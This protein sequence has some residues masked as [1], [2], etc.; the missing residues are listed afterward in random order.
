VPAFEP[1]PVISLLIAAAA[2]KQ[3]FCFNAI[4]IFGSIKMEKTGTTSEAL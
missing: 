4:L 1:A 2:I 3:T